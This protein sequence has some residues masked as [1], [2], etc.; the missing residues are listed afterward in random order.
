MKN[1]NF[2][3]FGGL[4]VTVG[5]ARPATVVGEDKEE[6]SPIEG[7]TISLVRSLVG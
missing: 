7:L 5:D 4:M 1:L 2:L 6:Q 3:V